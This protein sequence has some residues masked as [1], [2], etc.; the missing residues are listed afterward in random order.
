M[1]KFFEFL[2]YGA[3]LLLGLMIG[4]YSIPAILVDFYYFS[5]IY[6][7]F[8]FVAIAIAAFSCK[9]FEQSISF[10]TCFS[11]FGTGLIIAINFVIYKILTS[12]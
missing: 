8:L 11:F 1:S 3:S 5:F 10:S 2:I 9:L 12:F 4:L 7:V 6:I